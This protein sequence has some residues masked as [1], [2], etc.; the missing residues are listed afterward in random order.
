VGML[1][2]VLGW[3]SCSGGSG[4]NNNA[5]PPSARTPAGNYTV[6]VTGTSGSLSNTAGLTVTIN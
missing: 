5:P 4:D 6:T 2:V 1:F 3:A